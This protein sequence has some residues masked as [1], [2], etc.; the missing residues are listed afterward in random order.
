MGHATNTVS[1]VI[2]PFFQLPLATEEF[3]NGS[4]ASWQLV[5]Q[6]NGGALTCG[7]VPSLP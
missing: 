6:C 7:L 5:L 1:Q 4:M 2:S 3:E